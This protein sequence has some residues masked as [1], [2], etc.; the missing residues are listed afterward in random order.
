MH[1]GPGPCCRDTHRENHIWTRSYWNWRLWVLSTGP[2]TFLQPCLREKTDKGNPGAWSIFGHN[3]E[4][5]QQEVL[6]P[7]PE[8]ILKQCLLEPCTEAVQ[9]VPWAL[10][11]WLQGALCQCLL[12]TGIWNFKP[13]V[14][15]LRRSPMQSPLSE[16]LLNKVDDRMLPLRL[17][18]EP[19]IQ[20]APDG[21]LMLIH[22]L[23][24][25]PALLFHRFTVW[26]AFWSFSQLV[27]FNPIGGFSNEANKG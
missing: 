15:S 17:T 27:K 19:S 13:C 1:Q 10:L 2:I 12:L 11:L 5:S 4:G 26:F 18:T 23:C 9:A 20:K 25:H 8:R 14:S 24:M 16:R 6:L 21:H 7:L 3:P 22:C